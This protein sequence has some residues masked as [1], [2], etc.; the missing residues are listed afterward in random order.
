M[1][2]IKRA[3]LSVSNKE[4]ILELAKILKSFDIEILSTGGTAKLLKNNKIDVTE[5]SDYKIS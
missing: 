1:P 3:L 5:V 2:Q 4:N